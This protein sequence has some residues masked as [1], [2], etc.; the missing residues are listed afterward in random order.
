MRCSCGQHDIKT[1]D[2]RPFETCHF[3]GRATTQRAYVDWDHGRFYPS[4]C[5]ACSLDERVPLDG[6]LVHLAPPS[7]LERADN[8]RLPEGTPC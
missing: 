3:C 2:G 1:E 5:H 8:Y 6:L 4:I 7:E